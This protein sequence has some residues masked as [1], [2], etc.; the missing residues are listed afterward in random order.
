MSLHGVIFFNL[1]YIPRNRICRSKCAVIS[2]VM[3]N[4][5]RNAE[6]IYLPQSSENQVPSSLIAVQTLGEGYF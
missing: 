2:Y 5:S 4:S 3:L 6:L 1:G